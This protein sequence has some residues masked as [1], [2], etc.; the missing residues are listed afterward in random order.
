MSRTILETE[1]YRGFRIEISYGTYAESPR[2]WDNLGIMNCYHRKYDIGDKWY[3]SDPFESFKSW[4]EVKKH[5]IKNEDAGVILPVYMYEHSGVA[6][7]TTPFSCRFDSGQVGFIY[8]RR[9]DILQ[10]YRAKR[11]TKRIKSMTETL[12]V[13]EVDIYGKYLNGELY[14]YTVYLGEVVDDNCGGYFDQFE[15][16]IEAKRRVD[17]FIYRANINRFKYYLENA[18]SKD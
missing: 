16:M 8:A 9:S 3:T 13:N 7:S 1:D 5:I 15:A 18:Y 17:L 14:E 2:D 6:L 12:L 10:E 4:E 11:I